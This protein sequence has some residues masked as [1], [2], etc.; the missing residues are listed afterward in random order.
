MLRTPRA[1]R[2]WT[3]VFT[4]LTAPA[5]ADGLSRFE[6]ELKPKI[7]PELGLT[8]GRATALGA[9]GFTLEE[10]R[11]TIKDDTP[12]SAPTPVSIRRLTVEDLDFDGAKGKDG[13]NFLKMRAEGIKASGEFED[14]LKRY[15]LADGSADLIVDYRFEP[16][17][18]VLTLNKLEVVLPGLARF[19]LGL[20]MDNV[21]PDSV[22]KPDAA[23]DEATLRTATLVYEDSS[24][25]RKAL[26]ALA[27]EEKKSVD[28]WL[29]ETLEVIAVFA[30]GQGPRTLAVYDALAS[31]LRDHAAPK[32]PFRITVS[33]PAN[34]SAKDMDKLTVTNAI[35]D[36]FGL[37][38]S[39]A[40]TRAGAALEAKPKAAPATGQ[41]QRAAVPPAGGGV[42]CT[43]GQ[44][45]F[46]LSDG[47]WWSAT[48]REA[49]Q[50]GTRCVVRI[51]D[52]DDDIIV[53][54]RE[55][56]IPW[57]MDG[58]GKVAAGCRK[59]D[60]V[61]MKS[62]GAWYPA[63]VKLNKGRSCVVVMEDDDE[64][65]TVELRRLRVLR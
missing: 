33:P 28:A 22:S 2:A 49:T 10:V 41:T 62:E 7:P 21:L 64:E 35:V 54:T 6:Q 38:A 44:R 53:R 12:G 3:L 23:M 47:A 11:A 39:Y 58:P 57:S 34:V 50:T 43:P 5:S 31:F 60:K 9:S 27:A 40:G 48:V 16:A 26:P 51:E 61:L 63:D 46:A 52:E 36:V 8:Y 56:M 59:G 4:L 24:L 45:L 19:E 30:D 42:P 37:S 55:E 18:K 25:L 20:I 17:R 32:G 14:W 13:P 65:H 1:V 29:A 15:G